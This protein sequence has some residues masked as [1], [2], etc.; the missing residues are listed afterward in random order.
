MN[1]REQLLRYRWV[2]KALMHVQR[3]LWKAKVPFYRARRGRI[4]R[5]IFGRDTIANP[6]RVLFFVTDMAMWKYHELFTLMNGSERFSPLIVPYFPRKTGVQLMQRSRDGIKAYA[7]AHRFPFLDGYDFATGTYA[8]LRPLCPDIVVYTQPYNYGYPQWGIDA[9]SR[10]SLF[11]FTPY[12][13]AVAEGRQFRDTYLLNIAQYIF[14]SSPVEKEVYLKSMPVNTEALIITGSEIFDLI[15]HAD[16]MRSPWKSHGERKHLIWAPHHSIDDLNSFASSN[17][18]R[19][20]DAM[21]EI[22]DRYADTVEFAFKPHPL[23][24]KRLYDKWGPERT[25][26]YY[27]AWARK[28]NAFVATGPYI[29]L[30]AFSDAMI[31]DCSSFAAEYL[32]TGKPVMYLTAEKEPGV[33]LG[34]EYGRMC[35]DLHYRGYT[36]EEIERF[37]VQ[38]V[39]NGDDSMQNDRDMFVDSQLTPPNNA[40]PGENML[41]NLC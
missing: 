33:A 5:R 4:R 19:I 31:H 18:E 7:D 2:R 10:N 28:S 1:L 32:Y 41:K 3:L 38:T 35:F 8:D 17:F 9:F 25:D 12:G 40:T 24:R 13:A 30:F 11:A 29:E 6:V 34:N 23:L 20:A 15:K 36:I 14:V 27:N 16:A 21:L 39:I 22:A 37:I 26:T